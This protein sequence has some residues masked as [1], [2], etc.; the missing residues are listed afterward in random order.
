MEHKTGYHV[1]LYGV[2]YWHRTLRG[3]G[4]K[5]RDTGNWCNAQD[6]QCIEVATGND[7]TDQAW[8]AISCPE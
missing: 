7:M 4:S 3:A 8:E 1:W 2:R 6:A 5:L